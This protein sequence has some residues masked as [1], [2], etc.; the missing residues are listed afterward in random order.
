MGGASEARAQRVRGADDPAESPGAGGS[1]HT[2]IRGDG[3][4]Y[5]LDHEI[6]PSPC[7]RDLPPGG[8][9]LGIYDR[10]GE[11][12]SDRR[13]S[14]S[15]DLE[16]DVHTEPST[17]LNVLGVVGIVLGGAGTVVCAT[18]IGLVISPTG[19][20]DAGARLGGYLLFVPLLASVAI[21]VLGIVGALRGPQPAV[22]LQVVGGP[23]HA[24][25][26]LRGRWE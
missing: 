5:A 4:E 19:P 20:D 17:L 1:H 13:L 14:V 7:S 12:V 6:C 25:L 18:S 15:D 8:H 26:E 16:I 23:M 11:L 21:T 3:Y 24:G 2:T 10:S 9:V 22:Q